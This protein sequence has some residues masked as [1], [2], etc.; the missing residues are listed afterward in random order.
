MPHAIKL[1]KLSVPASAKT[2]SL[3]LEP[4]TNRVYDINMHCLGFFDPE[5]TAVEL[6]V[7]DNDY[8]IDS[9][10]GLSSDGYTSHNDIPSD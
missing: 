4:D 7:T 8:D 10:D 2:P 1:M 6:W 9:H 3:W 5:T